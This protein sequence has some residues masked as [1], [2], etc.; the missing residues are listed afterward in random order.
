MRNRVRIL[1]VLAIVLAASGDILPAPRRP[2]RGQANAEQPLP[3]RFSPT[4]QRLVRQLPAGERL[5]V[6]VHLDSSANLAPIPLNDLPRWEG[7]QQAVIETLQSR[8]SQAQKA[9]LAELRTAQARGEAGRVVSL[10]IDNSILV[11]ASPGLLAAL[12]QRPEVTQIVPDYD[13]ADPILPVGG[14]SGPEL[15]RTVFAAL[16]AGPPE[17]NLAVIGATDLWALGDTGQGITVALLDSGVDATHPDLTG[18]YRGGNNSWFDPYG[19][20]AAPFDSLGHGTWAAGVIVGDGTGNGTT[21]RSTGVAPGAQW[22]AAKIFPTAPILQSYAAVHLAFQW[23]LDPD[24]NPATPDAPQVVNNSWDFSTPG[25]NLEFQ[26]DLLALRAAG[27]LPV[28]AAGNA[29]PSANTSL[30]PANNLGAFSVGAVDNNGLIYTSSSRGANACDPARVFPSVVAPGVN[31][32]STDLLGGYI[33]ETGTSLAAPHASGGLALLLSAYPH[34]SPE[35]QEQLLVHGAVD[36]GTVGPDSDYGNGLVHLPAALA[37]LHRHFVPY[38]AVI[39]YR[40]YIP[41]IQN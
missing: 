36:L 37:A 28:F 22:I 11:E 34:L 21:S 17:P 10:W 6:I 15:A 8:A 23:V 38:M 5:A 26:P 14:S 39:P 9:L 19:Q 27:I 33:A 4:L 20:Y 29:G 13:P 2:V 30:S 12:A 40:V 18:R 32:Y 31:I 1:C 16:Q 24:G 41:L 3:E 35:L 7:R 25:C